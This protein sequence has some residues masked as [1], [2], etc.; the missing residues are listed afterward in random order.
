MMSTSAD[1]AQSC[2]RICMVKQLLA[3]DL[4]FTRNWFQSLASS[5]F[6]ITPWPESPL[7]AGVHSMCHRRA[8][9]WLSFGQKESI[10]CALHLSMV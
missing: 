10:L 1:K 8:S 5:S 2:Y 9:F 6:S 4:I 7:A 3:E